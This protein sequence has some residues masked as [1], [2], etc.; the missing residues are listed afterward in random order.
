MLTG[1]HVSLSG[2]TPGS[3]KSLGADEKLGDILDSLFDIEEG[4]ERGPETLRRALGDL[5]G[6]IIEQRIG[7]YIMPMEDEDETNDFT[8]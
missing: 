7:Y 2:H 5:L 6:R 8:T 4:I 3:P 1:I